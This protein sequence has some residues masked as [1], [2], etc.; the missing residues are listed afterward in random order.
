MI[1]SKAMSPT[2]IFRLALVALAL[3]ALLPS[4]PIRA[5]TLEAIGAAPDLT[6][7]QTISDEPLLGGQ[8]SYTITLRNPAPTPVADRGYNLSITDT[9]PLGLSFI[10]AD[11]A[12]SQVAAQ[13]DGTTLLIWDNLADLE[14]G[15]TLALSVSARL[16]ASLTLGMAFTNM[17]T[18]RL[19]SMPDNSGA[20]I[21]ATSS[22]TAQPQAL[23]LEARVAQSSSGHQV[24]GAGELVAAPGART[25]ADWPYRYHLTLRNNQVGATTAVSVT[26]ILPAGVAYLGNPTISPNPTGATVTPTLILH[27]DG[28]LVLR[29]AIGTL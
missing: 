18:A 28:S 15:E 13:A 27:E 9:L 16:D 11:P 14:A 1:W 19:N 29:W 20:W 24:S 7:S 3:L 22:L 4:K 10:A 17:V 25:G 6:I 12:P 23:D 21:N 5:A 2:R 8:V 26:A